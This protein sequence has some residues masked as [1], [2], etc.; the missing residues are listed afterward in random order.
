MKLLDVI[1]NG[2]VYTIAEMS[3]NHAGRLENAMA[4]IRAAKEAGA[5]CLK[6]QTYTADT[7]TLNCDNEHF[8][9]HGGLWDGYNMYQLYQDASTPWEWQRQIKEECERLDMDFL[10]TP[11]DKTSVDFLEELGVEAYKIASFEL[12]DTPLVKYVASKG[13][14]MIVS[15]GLATPEE[16]QQ[17]LD[18][19]HEMGNEQVFLLKCTSEYPAKFEDMRLSLIK[20][21]QE[22]FG[23]KIGL[24][25]HSMGSMAPV[26]AV[27]LGACIIEK[28]FCLDRNIQ[29][30]DAAFSMEPAEFAEMV[31]KVKLIGAALGKP[32]YELEPEEASQRHF[33]RSL[34]AGRD[35]AAGEAFTEENVRC[36]R[37]SVGLPPARYWEVLACK[38]ACDIPFG[39]PLMEDMLKNS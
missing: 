22:R 30:P 16:I 23:V 12:T 15:C 3:A 32:T 25:D 28:H 34:F 19:V 13:K 36:V 2:G 33:R 10:S 6:I 8:R 14:P 24:S 31:Q 29:N 21:M 18:A 4:I 26:I 39:T 9:I 7:I 37:P 27:S 20:D 1:Q 11:F 5:D 17:M 35:I 38:A